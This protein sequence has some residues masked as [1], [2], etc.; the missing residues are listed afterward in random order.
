MALQ[1]II[2]SH[3]AKPRHGQQIQCE[4][5]SKV[6]D[7][8]F[9]GLV[10][11][12]LSALWFAP[13]ARAN[14]PPLTDEAPPTPEHWGRSTSASVDTRVDTEFAPSF[15]FEDGSEA[16]LG[17]LG[18]RIDGTVRRSRFSASI[19][20]SVESQNYTS[21]DN[22]LRLLGTQFSLTMGYQSDSVGFFVGPLL[23]ISAE[24]DSDLGQAVTAGG[25]AGV[26]WLVHETLLVGAGVY[27]SSQLEGRPLVLPIPIFNWRPIEQFRVTSF[28]RYGPGGS[29]EVIGVPHRVVE[30][31]AGFTYR[32]QQF[33]L[34][35]E[36]TAQGGVFESTGVPVW[37]GVAL[38]PTEWMRIDTYVG[39]TFAGNIKLREL[40]GSDAYAADY[41]PNVTVGLS[42]SLEFDAARSAGQ[43]FAQR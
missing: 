18:T 11:V 39:T 42:L 4:P 41:N 25:A 1:I 13:V 23:G 24:S 2:G 34:D 7:N 14:E 16:E 38:F 22:D 30:L 31:S 35:S 27:A 17:R 29:I 21:T 15:R 26:T 9:P 19:G 8:R 32:N 40:D 36:G 3:F 37:F 43:Q 5:T 6:G 10:V 33:R 12:A 28:G 20:A